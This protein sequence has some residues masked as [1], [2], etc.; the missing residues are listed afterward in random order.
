METQREGEIQAEKLTVQRQSEAL[1]ML[2][3][4]PWVCTEKES[5]KAAV[6]ALPTPHCEPSSPITGPTP[7]PIPQRTHVLTLALPVLAVKSWG[8]FAEQ[9]PSSESS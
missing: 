9:W 1:Q 6:P 4:E 8:A 2:S 7:T 5:K 3:S